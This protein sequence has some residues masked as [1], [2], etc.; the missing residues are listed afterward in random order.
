MLAALSETEDPDSQKAAGKRARAAPG[1]AGAEQERQ[2]RAAKE[3]MLRVIFTPEARERLSNIR[4]V[5]PDLAESI[6]SQII[7]L[8]ASGRLRKQ[9]GDEELKQMLGSFQRPKK[10][11]KI[12]WK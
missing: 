5:R 1:T 4:M 3:Q 2:E 6:E 12:N 11:F 10:E 9:I 7:Q 8:A